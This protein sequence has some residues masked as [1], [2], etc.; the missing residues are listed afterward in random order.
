MIINYKHVQI[1]PLEKPQVEPSR[2][3]PLEEECKYKVWDACLGYNL[4]THRNSVR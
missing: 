1:T 4:R 3:E 2:H